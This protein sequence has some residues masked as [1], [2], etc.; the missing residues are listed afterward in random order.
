MAVVDDQHALLVAAHALLAPLARLLVAGRV[1][2]A[3]AQRLLQATMVEA[4]R[5]AHADA[6]PHEVASLIA[7]DTGLAL[8]DLQRLGDA[9]DLAVGP[10]RSLAAELFTRWRTHPAYADAQGRPRVL[11][12]LGAAPSFE[13]LSRSVSPD[14]PPSSLLNE[15]VR[16]GMAAYLPDR[17]VVVL[18]L[19]AYVPSADLSRMLQFLAHNVGD[20]LS[21]AVENV[22]GDSPRHVERA[23]FVNGLSRDS[24]RTA[25]DWVA[26]CWEQMLAELA[27]LLESLLARDEADPARA[28]TH[29]FRAGLYGFDCPADPPAADPP[30]TAVPAAAGVRP[31][32]GFANSIRDAFIGGEL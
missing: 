6:P 19:G 15:L 27:P 21:A 18:V 25:N 5:Q 3:D 12:R 16:L 31:D 14:R 17:D 7:R 2:V 11:P 4:A 24:V 10:Q 23:V 32:A 30:T 29:R 26:S 1:P 8:R 9:P 22:V 28:R 20:H 13:T